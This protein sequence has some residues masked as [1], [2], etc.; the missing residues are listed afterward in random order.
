MSPLGSR[1][2]PSPDKCPS[3]S[4]YADT[5]GFFKVE[6]WT[7][8]DLHVARLILCR[9]PARKKHTTF[10]TPPSASTWPGGITSAK[11]FAS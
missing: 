6:E 7:A 11:A 9:Q 10:S 1:D 5:R 2:P 8:D 3:G 4:V